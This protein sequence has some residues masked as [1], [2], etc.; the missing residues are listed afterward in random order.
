M[1]PES[2]V[3][4]TIHVKPEAAQTVRRVPVFAYPVGFEF[5]EANLLP[6]LFLLSMG[7]FNSIVSN[8][9]ARGARELGGWMMTSVRRA[10]A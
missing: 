3:H 2:A 1:K 9:G 6:R 10:G 5:Q 7:L 4:I 8:N